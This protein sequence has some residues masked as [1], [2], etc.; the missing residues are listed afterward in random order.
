MVCGN[1]RARQV[2]AILFTEPRCCCSKQVVSADPDGKTHILTHVPASSL[3]DRPS[4]TSVWTAGSA[5]TA[6][7]I[8]W[9][10]GAMTTTPIE[11][12][13]TWTWIGKKVEVVTRMNKT[14]GFITPV[15]D[16]FFINRLDQ[17]TV[18]T[19]SGH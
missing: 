18:P 9:R 3:L 14:C 5:V 13:L 15:K 11:Y 1:W 16:W 19:I 4:V 6:G 2:V 17:Y 10:T 12:Y 7:S 8:K